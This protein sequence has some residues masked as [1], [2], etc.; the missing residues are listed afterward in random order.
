LRAS[1]PT[2]RLWGCDRDAAAMAAAQERLAEFS[3]RCELRQ[4]NFAE[5]AGW[6]APGSCDGVLLDLGAS[7]HQLDQAARGFSFVRD[8]PLDMRMDQRQA[9]TAAELVNGAEADQLAAW[10]WELGGERQARRLARGIVRERERRPFTTTGQ[11]AEV[12]A[13]LA[14]RAGRATHPATRCFKALRAAV[15]DELGSLSRGLAAA[16]KILKVGGRLAVITFDSAEDRVVKAF[17]RSLERDYEAAGVDVP[18]LRR[19]RPR[20]LRWVNRRALR[21]RAAE[22]EANPGAR[23]AQ[24]RGMEKLAATM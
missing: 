19:P 24:L 12:I 1:A 15:N 23:S 14:P 17:G 5:L 7:A 13:R 21:P 9:L 18:E 16:W 11:L 20:Q 10:F 6:I 4:A 22:I 2:G 3:G 8:G